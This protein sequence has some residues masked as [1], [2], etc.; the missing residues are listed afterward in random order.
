MEENDGEEHDM[1]ARACK[2]SGVKSKNRWE[3]EAFEEELARKDMRISSEKHASPSKRNSPGS[4]DALRPLP[5][6]AKEQ[7]VLEPQK[8]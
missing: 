8:A 7:S 1:S 5:I 4:Q 2:N 6:R 3:T